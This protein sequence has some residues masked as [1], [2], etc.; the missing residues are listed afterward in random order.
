MLEADELMQSRVLGVS[1]G[2]LVDVAAYDAVA[3]SIWAAFPHETGS[4]PEHAMQASSAWNNVGYRA[5]AASEHRAAFAELFELEPAAP[6]ETRYSQN[7]HFFGFVTNA[8]ACAESLIHAAYMIHLG[9][10]HV[11]L[12][13]KHL[14]TTPEIAL[15]A[16]AADARFGSL[17][18][19]LTH[20]RQRPVAQLLSDMRDT[21]M[22]RSSPVRNHFV[23]GAK[24]GKSM[25]ARNPKSTP[26]S[27]VN[28]F[29]FN[30]QACDNFE[31]WLRELLADA[32][33]ELG[34]AI[35]KPASPT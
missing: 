9:M 27:W 17:V 12:T 25:L 26:A 23:G 21:L 5:R 32:M 18:E 10:T 31:S 28:E 33:T 1:L 24:H 22:H 16:L 15:K 34:A 20:H 11:A 19:R 30:A 29:E 3:L 14:R 7:T 35:P 4:P 13:D 6:H 2:R 8:V